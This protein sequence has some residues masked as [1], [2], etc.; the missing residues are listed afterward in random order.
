MTRVP[1]TTIRGAAA[2]PRRAAA[3]TRPVSRRPTARPDPERLALAV[4]R[5][6]LEV[7]AGRRSL[8]QLRPVMAP[9]LHDRLMHELA[10]ARPRL[11]PATATTVGEIT[12]VI[13]AWPG[14]DACEITVLVR[15][16]ARTTAVA[17]RLDRYRATWRVTDLDAPESRTAARR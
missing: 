16:A 9:V 17:L 8:I 2:I 7:L 6:Y 4:T 5:A 10:R 11:A 12:H 3:V 14:D 1:G 13:S 15:R